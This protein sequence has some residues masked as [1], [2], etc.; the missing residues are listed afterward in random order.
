MLRVL[1]IIKGAEKTSHASSN[2]AQREFWTRSMPAFQYRRAANTKMKR[3]EEEDN[4]I[5]KEENYFREQK[6][7]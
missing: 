4:K 3:D 1:L 7:K 5:S 6:Y 2:I